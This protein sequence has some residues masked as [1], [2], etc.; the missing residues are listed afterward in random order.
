MMTTSDRGVSMRSR[1][2]FLDD[3][4]KPDPGHPSRAVVIGGFSVPSDLVPTLTRRISGAKARFFPNRPSP[5]SWEIKASEIIK[6]NPWKRRKN[7]DFADEIVRI[8]RSVDGTVYSAAITKSRMIHQLTLAQTMPLQIQALAEHFAVECGHHGEMGLIVADWS[9]HHADE[10][11]S[12]CVASF[13]AS[14]KLD[15]HPSVYYAS[16]M[17]TP[18][19]QVADLI[20]ALFR[21]AEE[22]DLGLTQLAND[23]AGVCSLP[24]G[25]RPLTIHQRRY[26][27]RTRLF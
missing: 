4:G 25:V 21:R 22:G 3:S 1:V 20:A 26:Q 16:S 18:A 6:P 19:I 5:N 24:L 7:R 11:A 2:L 10:H 23:A 15:L 8:L 17:G 12:H 14:R 27:N 9:S 13:V